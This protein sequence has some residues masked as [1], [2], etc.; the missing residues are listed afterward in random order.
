[1]G[2]EIRVDFVEILDFRDKSLAST[3]SIDL[4][5]PKVRNDIGGMAGV[6]LLTSPYQNIRFC[7]KIWI[8]EIKDIIKC[9]HW[10]SCHWART[11]RPSIGLLYPKVRNNIGGGIPTDVDPPPYQN[12]RGDVSPR[13]HLRSAASHQLVVQ[14]Y[15]LSSYGRR[16]FSVV[17][18]TT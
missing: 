6:F 17:G 3:I 11:T 12:S 10:A 8:S 1:M 15:R 16:A 7:G 2:F 5:Y 14:S 4:L 18:P 13:H 9:C